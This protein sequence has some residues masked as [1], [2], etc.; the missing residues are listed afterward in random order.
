MT[1]HWGDFSQI[2]GRLTSDEVHRA[3][4]SNGF[5]QKLLAVKPQYATDLGY[6]HSDMSLNTIGTYQ[7]SET[8]YRNKEKRR[9][10][11]AGLVGM[12][13]YYVEEYQ[14]EV[15]HDVDLSIYLQGKF[16]PVVYGVMRVPG[17]PVFADTLNNDPNT[18][19]VAYAIS[20]GEIQGI[21]NMY[22]D[23]NSLLCTDEADATTRGTGA[24]GN[25]AL[26]CYGRMD[27]GNV[28]GG[29]NIGGTLSFTEWLHENDLFE[30]YQEAL[31]N[32]RE[33]RFESMYQDFLTA[34]ESNINNAT[35]ADLQQGIGHEISA[36]IS[37]PHD[38]DFTFHQGRE[39]QKASSI[40]ATVAAGDNFKRQNSYYSGNEQYWSS[41]HTLLDT[42]Y[43]VVKFQIDADSTT[44]P[45][46][47]YVVK[48]KA[49]ECFNYDG[50]FV[51]DPVYQA[52]TNA[53]YGGEADSH[54]N[55]KEGD[56]VSVETSFDGNTWQSETGFRILHKYPLVTTRGE[57]Q[58]RFILDNQPNLGVK[59][60]TSIEITNPGSG[61]TSN[62]TISLS[63]GGGS[64]AT[65]S[66]LNEQRAGG[67]AG[68]FGKKIKQPSIENGNLK[69]LYL[70]LIHI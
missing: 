49:L 70:S 32:N 14:V 33:S 6:L 13:K 11:L 61:F 28:L 64:G 2:A 54:T 29:T 59:G 53:A 4:D 16:L 66:A 31:D 65:V 23:G 57:T 42:A 48:G 63:G 37:S 62:P 60:V 1:S 25:T 36:S 52:S 5:P 41:D 56:I 15:D 51:H 27:R 9:G 30:D 46:M 34:N 8:R 58:Y 38:I 45:E 44:V 19:Y 50:T 67:I 24:T 55:F 40:L 10:G 68:L 47:E 39:F 3:L 26:T 22:I 7:T 21:Y 20:E 18:I 12:K 43:V 69:R 35:A 17:I